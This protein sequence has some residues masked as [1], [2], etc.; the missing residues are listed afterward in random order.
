MSR[1]VKLGVSVALLVAVVMAGADVASAQQVKVD[2]AVKPYQPVPGI[3]GTLNGKGSDTL[4][5]MMQ[6]WSEAFMRH[7]PNA[8]ATYTGEGSGTAPPALI[9][10]TAQLGP[11][12]RPMKPEEDL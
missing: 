8:Q 6:M 7:Y 2:P 5:N 11:M 1:L 3:S 9:E 10:G 4:Q 12:S